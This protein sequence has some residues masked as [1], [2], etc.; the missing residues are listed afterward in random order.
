MKRILLLTIAAMMT[1]GMSSVYAHEAA[2][3]TEKTEKKAKKAKAEIKE[4][5]FHVDLHCKAC[6]EKVQ[7]HI[8]FEKGV[9]G[10]EISLENHS[11][12]IK[13]DAAKTSEETLRAAIEKLGYKVSEEGHHDHH[14]H[15]GHSH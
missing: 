2:A 3:H 14:H 7:A 10:L 8:A 11:I 13:Y 6:V 4:V 9:K 5:T 1:L 12:A 15:H